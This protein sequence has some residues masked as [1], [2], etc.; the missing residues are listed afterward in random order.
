[1]ARARGG[2]YLRPAAVYAAACVLLL[3]ELNAAP[4]EFIR[5]AVYPD[6]VTLWLKRTPMRGGVVVLP[7]GPNFN[8]L[9]MLRSADHE[10]PLVVG[11]SGFGSPYEDR[12]EEYD[13]RRARS[14]GNSSN[15]SKRLRPPTSSS[16][17]TSSRLSRR[18]DYATFLSRAVA[19]GRLRFVNRF[20]GSDDLYAVV[21]TE[22]DARAEASPPAEL[23]LRDWASMLD[24]DSL[25][26][27]GQYADWSRAIYRLHLVARGRMPRYAEFMPDARALGRGLIPAAEE[28]QARLRRTSRRARARM[29][30]SRGVW[31]PLRRDGRRAFRRAALRERGR[32]GRRRGARRAR[33]RPLFADGDARGRAPQGGRGPAART[34]A[35]GNAPSLLLHY[36]AFLRRNPDDP[37]DH[38]LTG[39]D[40]WLSNLERTNDPDKVALA[41]RDS[42]EYRAMK[43]Q[44]MSD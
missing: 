4:L 15:C 6:A 33:R 37:P 5:G 16:R 24:E 28:A 35:G 11:I 29:G 18:T 3:A 31:R 2:R 7:A 44:M 1:M 10:K 9:H 22:P 27:L 41:F 19:A 14:R 12:I 36:F 8:H 20:D 39:F 23:E 26:L 34:D 30:E 17:T 32:R 13:A 42:I 38:D 40:F 25:N 43:K 21:R